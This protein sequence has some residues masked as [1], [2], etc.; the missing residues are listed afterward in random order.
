MKMDF[1]P[2][3]CTA[4]MAIMIGAAASHYS[5][6]R[7]MIQLA[8]GSPAIR[9]QEPSPAAPAK[10]FELVE[11]LR[12]Q[13]ALLQANL[14]A[15]SPAVATSAPLP[16]STASTHDDLQHFLSELVQ[17]NQ[18]LQTKL[19]ETNR[20]VMALEFRVD[21]HSEQFRPLHVSDPGSFDLDAPTAIPLQ[22]D[23]L[24]NDVGVLPPLDLP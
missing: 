20:D 13:N 17:Q 8:E 23:S 21:S 22:E 9:P 1:V 7:Q 24:R 19:A 18:D 2:I 4:A 3:A 16:V 11:H 10:L 15:R 5:S 14:D 6:V 12:E